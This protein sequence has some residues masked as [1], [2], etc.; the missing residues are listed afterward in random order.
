MV[1]SVNC[2]WKAGRDLHGNDLKLINLSDAEEE[3]KKRMSRINIAQS[4]AGSS[5]N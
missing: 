5:S 4:G 1:N 2:V 3:E